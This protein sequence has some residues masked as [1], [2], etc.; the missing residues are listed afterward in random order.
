MWS[1]E[2]IPGVSFKVLQDAP[3]EGSGL[4]TRW[5]VE[6]FGGLRRNERAR[7]WFARHVRNAVVHCTTA[8]D[9]FVVTGDSI[10][11]YQVRD[12]GPQL[13]GRVFDQLSEAQRRDFQE[14]TGSDDPRRTFSDFVDSV[15][16]THPDQDRLKELCKEIAHLFD[17]A[18]AAVF[19]TVQPKWDT[20]EQTDEWTDEKNSRR[21][22]LSDKKIQDTLHETER[23]ELELLQRQAVAYRDRVA[24][25]PID[26]ARRLHQR[27]LERKRKD[28][29]Q[30]E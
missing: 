2:T 18:S 30:G 23:Q 10:H 15:I 22:N 19:V 7:L 27:L 1:K 26:G 24:P 12:A 21:I 17:A 13:G 25:L 20:A 28:E 11:F 9:A 4:A 14:L 8:A 16:T 5:A 3:D 29:Q 6:V